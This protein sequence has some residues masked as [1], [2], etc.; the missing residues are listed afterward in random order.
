MKSK[1]YLHVHL[2]SVKLSYIFLLAFAY[3]SSRIFKHMTLISPVFPDQL[4]FFP[5]PMSYWKAR[6]HLENLWVPINRFHLLKHEKTKIILQILIRPENTC[7]C[8]LKLRT[9]TEQ[10]SYLP[11]LISKIMANFRKLF[12]KLL[13]VLSVLNDNF[14]MVNIYS[15]F[16]GTYSSTDTR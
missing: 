5:F 4:L 8:H 16:P 13:H 6:L 2:I 7:S 1:T 14:G 3:N 10:N 12:L 15:R 11:L 9:H